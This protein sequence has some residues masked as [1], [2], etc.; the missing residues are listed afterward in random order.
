MRSRVSSSLVSVVVVMFLFS[1]TALADPEQRAGW[2]PVASSFAPIVPLATMTGMSA[3]AGA[4][5][6]ALDRRRR[7]TRR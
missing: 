3:V 5:A 4:I 1:A 7:H 6:L 2:K